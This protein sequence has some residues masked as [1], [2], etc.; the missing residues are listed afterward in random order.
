[1]IF[2]RKAHYKFG[3]ELIGI[4]LNSES[5][6]ACSMCARSV[7][8]ASLGSFNFFNES[9]LGSHFSSLS[10]LLCLIQ[11]QIIGGGGS[12]PPSPPASDGLVLHFACIK[13]HL[14][15][16]KNFPK[17]DFSTFFIIRAIFSSFSIVF[18]LENC[19]FLG[20]FWRK[21]TRGPYRVIWT[22]REPMRKLHLGYE[23][24]K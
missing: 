15:H 6:I 12:S 3:N 11:I 24:G 1:M 16:D 19:L 9:E 5:E 20:L 13:A 7:L 18:N 10:V 14:K 17:V 4:E 21:N 8:S 2:Y 22:S 23:P